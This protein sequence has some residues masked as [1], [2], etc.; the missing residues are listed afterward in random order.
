M[1]FGKNCVGSNVM[2]R[3]RDT[4]RDIE[5]DGGRRRIV[6][7]RAERRKIEVSKRNGGMRQLGH[8]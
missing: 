1:G 5:L 4:K 2:R 7:Q 8:G 6:R 3:E